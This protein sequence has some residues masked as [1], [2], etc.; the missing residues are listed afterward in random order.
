MTNL[1]QNSQSAKTSPAYL[2]GYFDASI[3]LPPKTDELGSPYFTGYLAA[4]AK[5]GQTPF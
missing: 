3:G 5:T 2:N 4:V 1:T